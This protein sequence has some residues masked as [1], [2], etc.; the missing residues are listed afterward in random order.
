MMVS[1]TVNKLAE[2]QLFSTARGIVRDIIYPDGLGYDSSVI[3]ICIVEF[4]DYIGPPM[5]DAMLANGMGK[6]IAIPA[7]ERRC[8]SKCCSRFGIPLVVSKAASVHSIQGLTAGPQRAIEKI[9]FHWN[10]KCEALWPNIA[11]V[12]ISR[13]ESI[14]CLTFSESVT[15]VDIHSIGS[16]DKWKKQNIEVERIMGAAKKKREELAVMGEGTE[17]DFVQHIQWLLFYISARSSNDVNYIS[18]R[19]IFCDANYARVA[20][21][22]VGHS[23]SLS[24]CNVDFGELAMRVAISAKSSENAAAV[25][26]S[27][28][29][30][31]CRE[32]AASKTKTALAAKISKS[33]GCATSSVAVSYAANI[34]RVT[35]DRG[36]IEAKSKVAS[37]GRDG[38]IHYAKKRNIS[39]T[40]NFLDLPITPG[41]VGLVNLGN[42]CY[43][44]SIIQ[45]L[46]SLSFLTYKFL[47]SGVLSSFQTSSALISAYRSLLCNIWDNHQNVQAISPEKMFQLFQA[48]SSGFEFS[49][50]VQ[51]DA[52]EFMSAF[53]SEVG[54]SIESVENP[55]YGQILGVLK[56][57]VCNDLREKVEPIFMLNIE[58]VDEIKE[59][60]S[61][62]IYRCFDSFFSQQT[63]ADVD[64]V[65]CQTKRETDIN[66]TILQA[67]DTLIICFKRFKRLNFSNNTSSRINTTVTFPIDGFDVSRYLYNQTDLS[68]IYDLQAVCQHSGD[69]TSGHYTAVC[70]NEVTNTW[71]EILSCIYV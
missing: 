30:N 54:L 9:V 42:T 56:C 11:Y 5:N 35:K 38:V 6:W 55:F 36:N 24:S 4:C 16:S 19:S 29:I 22:S 39:S 59:G 7:E 40:S 52:Q 43:A 32:E 69:L 68:T 33:S 14:E 12:G 1:L 44:S 31:K 45:C 20:E 2:Y 27:E 60:D 3:P 23:C 58:I 48:S 50:G 8:D 57:C 51:S 34:E 26:S 47:S 49:I 28:K 46:S 70:K 67:P 18:Q 61:V 62:S 15:E 64:C 63:S 25:T 65:N 41:A 66:C 21:W 71:Y 37:S 10:G 53:L 13:V 17:E